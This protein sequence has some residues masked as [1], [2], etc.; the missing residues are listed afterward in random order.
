MQK[1]FTLLE[2]IVVIVIIGI[3][4]TLGFTQYTKIVER[5]RETEAMAPIG[6]MTKLAYNYY[7]VHGTFVGIQNADSEVGSSSDQL[8]DTCVSTNYF[9]YLVASSD[10]SNHVDLN[11]ERC[12]S[13][14]KNPNY[15]VK[16][17]PY[18]RLWNNGT[19]IYYCGGG[20][21]EGNH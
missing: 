10:Y 19:Q 12:T 3:L 11:A 18:I 6:Y 5:G 14:G 17:N 2:L 4:A 7:L 13:G 1:G 8:P 15:T 9:Y 21:P 16:Y 20:C